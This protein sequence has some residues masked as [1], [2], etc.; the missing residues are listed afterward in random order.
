M[1]AGPV[2]VSGGQIDSA[3][4]ERIVDL[5]GEEALA[6]NLAERPVGNHVA[7]GAD[8]QDRRRVGA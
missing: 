7:A 1:L 3:I 5:L 2:D 4:E 6:P 8:R